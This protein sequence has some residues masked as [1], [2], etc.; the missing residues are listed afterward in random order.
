MQKRDVHPR[1][2]KG[3]KIDLVQKYKCS[4]RQKRRQIDDSFSEKYW[5]AELH[6][7]MLLCLGI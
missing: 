1:H 7:I 4:K 6:D 3:L 2:D 5:V